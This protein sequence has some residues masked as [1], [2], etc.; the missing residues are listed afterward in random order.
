MLSGEKTSFSTTLAIRISR[1]ATPS[2]EH[3]NS[4][5]RKKPTSGS[6][7]I[8]TRTKNKSAFHG[9]SC[10]FLAFSFEKP[11]EFIRE[12]AGHSFP[13]A[14]SAYSLAKNLAH[15]CPL[16]ESAG[17]PRPTYLT[18]VER[19]DVSCECRWLLLNS[20]MEILVRTMKWHLLL[21][22]Y[23][24]FFPPLTPAQESDFARKME[25]AKLHRHDGKRFRKA[26]LEKNPQ[27]FLLYYSASW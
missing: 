20:A 23:L 26:R 16:G 14:V 6:F 12:A 8:L 18:S 19:S 13:F 4:S 27:Y 1:H 2:S 25:K 10:S 11:F 15:P 7:M 17:T 22:V 21:L 3:R 5:G 24:F 9:S